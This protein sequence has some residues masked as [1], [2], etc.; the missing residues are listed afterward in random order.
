[1]AERNKRCTTCGSLTLQIISD[2]KWKEVAIALMSELADRGAD[3][4]SAAVR[5]YNHARNGR[6]N[7]VRQEL[8]EQR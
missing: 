6:W 5:A 4:F 7:D 8:E 1:M 3:P 2:D